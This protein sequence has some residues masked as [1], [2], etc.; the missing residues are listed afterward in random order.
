MQVRLLLI[1]LFFIPSVATAKLRNPYW[2]SVRM[3]GTGQ[4]YWSLSQGLSR[5]QKRWDGNGS[6]KNRRKQVSGITYQAVMNQLASD[7][8]VREK[9]RSGSDTYGQ[10]AEIGSLSFEVAHRDFSVAPGWYYGLSSWWNLGVRLPIIYRDVSVNQ[11]VQLT[12]SVN[13]QS[14]SN[15]ELVELGQG[16][17]SAALNQLQGQGFEKPV[18][19]RQDIFLS[20]IALLNKIKIFQNRHFGAVLLNEL[21]YPATTTKDPNYFVDPMDHANHTK[22]SLATLMQQRIS[23]AWEWIGY[24][25]Y[26]WQL[27]E[28]FDQRMPGFDGQQLRMDVVNNLVRDPGDRGEAWL[29]V[30]FKAWTR[31]HL[32]L[33]YAVEIKAADTVKGSLDEVNRQRLEADTAQSRQTLM[34]G[35]HIPSWSHI[36]WGG[37]PMQTRLSLAQDIAG[38]NVHEATTASIDFALRFF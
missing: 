4:S 17:E 18:G 1:F 27:A 25:G 13:S 28:K 24:M 15:S 14:Y 19:A 32:V 29:E 6:L 3:A 11:S 22:I 7:A 2:D 8:S 37:Q 10:S 31:V 35:V 23:A 9:V 5:T 34:A 38:Q 21:N 30:E 36:I 33:A 20:E 16:I 26:Q 12:D